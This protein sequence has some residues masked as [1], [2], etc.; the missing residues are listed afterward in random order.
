MIICDEQKCTGCFA[1]MNLCPNNAISVGYDSLLKTIP[2][3]DEAKCC[4]CNL[5]KKN[6]PVLNKLEPFQVK[7]VFAATSLDKADQEN[8]SSGGMAA[9]ITRQVIRSG[10]VV[11]G[12]AAVYGDVR[13]IRV[14]N[15]ESA[16]LLQGSK[17][18]QS[19]IGMIYRSV[20]EDLK[21]KKI[22]CFFGTPCQIAGLERFLLTPYD[23]LVTVD[24]VCH[25][26]PPLKYLEEHMNNIH[27]A[28]WDKLIFR[29]GT[30]FVL[31]AS[32]GDTKL[33]EKQAMLDRY[34][35]A[36]LTSLSYRDNCY[37]C[38][39]A[40][41]ER[42]SDITLGD[43]WGIDR[44]SLKKQFDGRISLVLINTEK[45]EQFFRDCHTEI[46]CEEREI[47]EGLNGNQENLHH[48]SVPH[49][50]RKKFEK[51]LRYKGFCY[52]VKHTQNERVIRKN[53]LKSK[54]VQSKLYQWIRC[55]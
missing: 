34:F 1:C 28:D 12:A 53:S 36:F 26:T 44:S 18:V 23:N 43:F 41:E 20:R 29:K 7:K 33:Y 51:N 17:Y 24:L 14:D 11:Y 2:I 39:Y 54:I 15:M 6:C 49:S 3:V 8:S 37:Q 4:H 50:D 22:V 5:C 32:C 16:K 47:K 35:K 10:G 48:P 9:V 40:R 52:A 21:N 25:G 19:T 31:M 38:D 45:G 30:S 27:A 42:I 46:V 13:H 55:R